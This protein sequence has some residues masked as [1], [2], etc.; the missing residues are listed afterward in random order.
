VTERL[1]CVM[2][3][4]RLGLPGPEDDCRKMALEYVLQ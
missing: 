2:T 3:T 4:M 1:T